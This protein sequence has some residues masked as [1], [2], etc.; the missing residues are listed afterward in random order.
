MP[1]SRSKRRTT[2]ADQHPSESAF[3]I[4]S[5]GN[6]SEILGRV[7]QA[8]LAKL[9]PPYSHPK[10]DSE[11]KAF[12]QPRQRAQ[13]LER[14]DNRVKLATKLRQSASRPPWLA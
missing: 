6:V 2:P 12:R 14:S 11:G 7:A 8:A 4:D 5:E 13:A 3:T 10:A 9:Q 1:R